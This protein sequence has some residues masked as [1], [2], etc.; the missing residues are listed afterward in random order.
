M[1]PTGEPTG[2]GVAGAATSVTELQLVRALVSLG[3]QLF[4]SLLSNK[5]APGPSTSVPE[6]TLTVL[7]VHVGAAT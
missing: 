7:V 4:E 1:E 6:Q 2:P 5:L 3:S